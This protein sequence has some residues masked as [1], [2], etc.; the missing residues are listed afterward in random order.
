M[1]KVKKH[2]ENN[3]LSGKSFGLI[4]IFKAWNLQYKTID[5]TKNTKVNVDNGITVAKKAVSDTVNSI[6]ELNSVVVSWLNE[7][8]IKGL[9]VEGTTVVGL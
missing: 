8:E 2:Q 9:L 7:V 3:Y 6:S 4:R 5:D 1:F